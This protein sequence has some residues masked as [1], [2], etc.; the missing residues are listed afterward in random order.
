MTS[1]WSQTYITVE[2]EPISRAVLFRAIREGVTN[3]RKHASATVLTI[4]LSTTRTHIVAEVH[5]DGRGSSIESGLGLMT[6]RERLEAIGGTL[7]VGAR[8][9]RG[10]VFRATVPIGGST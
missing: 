7:D 6:T 5:D 8:G 3:A 1:L 2:P 10:T 4:R 9:G